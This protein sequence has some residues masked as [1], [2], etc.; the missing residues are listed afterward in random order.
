MKK[1]RRA[2]LASVLDEMIPLSL[3]VVNS[4]TFGC[5]VALD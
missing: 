4:H 1:P 3:S 2:V 5:E